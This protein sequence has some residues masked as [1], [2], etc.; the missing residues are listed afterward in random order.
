VDGVIRVTDPGATPMA[1]ATE[2]GE[3]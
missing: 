3:E 2:G 1:H